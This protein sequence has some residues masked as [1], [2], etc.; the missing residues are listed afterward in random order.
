MAFNLT[1]VLGLYSLY[2]P[3]SQ[4]IAHRLLLMIWDKNDFN[5]WANKIWEMLFHF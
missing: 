1:R 2:P 5:L 4:Q 3:R